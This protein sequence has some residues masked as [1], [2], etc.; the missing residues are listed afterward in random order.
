[1]TGSITYTC[2]HT[3]WDRRID[4]HWQADVECPDCAVQRVT[5]ADAV[6]DAQERE[7]PCV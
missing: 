3:V 5:E 7:E 4:K 2:D 6:R 1:M